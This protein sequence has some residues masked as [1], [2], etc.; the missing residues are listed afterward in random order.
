MIGWRYMEERRIRKL[1]RD[2]MLE[3]GTNIAALFTTGGVIWIVVHWLWRMRIVFFMAVFLISCGA[4]PLTTD[5]QKL[6]IPPVNAPQDTAVPIP[7][8]DACGSGTNTLTVHAGDTVYVYTT[9]CKKYTV[10]IDSLSPVHLSSDATIVG[11]DTEVAYIN[12]APDCHCI[13]QKTHPLLWVRGTGEA[14]IYADG[15]VEKGK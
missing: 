1:R 9:D 6:A 5:S 12:D 13:E 14:I 2:R 10:H 15:T 4:S 7:T 8:H 11:N 3:I